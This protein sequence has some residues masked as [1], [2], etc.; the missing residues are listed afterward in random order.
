MGKPRVLAHLAEQVLT[1]DQLQWPAPQV[2]KLQSLSGELLVLGLRNTADHVRLREI[3]QR[4]EALGDPATGTGPW[5]DECHLVEIAQRA[6]VEVGYE[7]VCQEV[8]DGVE[9]P[10]GRVE[11]ML[12]GA[13]TYI[14]LAA[15]YFTHVKIL[16]VVGDDFAQEDRDLL[17]GRGIDVPGIPSVMI[18]KRSWSLGTRLAVDRIL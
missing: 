10:H 13:C 15:S 12:G 6:V 16:G 1:V 2:A 4:I 7:L 9:T 3:T 11:R 14:S 17:A 5:D 8:P 18:L